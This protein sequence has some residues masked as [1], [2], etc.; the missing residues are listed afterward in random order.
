MKLKWQRKKDQDTE[1]SLVHTNR[2]SDSGTH[3]HSTSSTQTLF[4]IQIY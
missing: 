1:D 3:R 2:T 4:L